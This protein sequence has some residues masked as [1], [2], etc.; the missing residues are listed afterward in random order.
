MIIIDVEN[1]FGYFEGIM[2]LQMME[3]FC[4]QVECF[5]ID[6]CYEL[7]SKVDFIGLVY[8]VWI[9]FGQEIYVNSIII[10]I[11]VSVKWL[12]L[13]FEK[14]LINKGVFVCVVCDG[15]FFCGMEIVIVGGGDMVVEEVLYFFKFSLKVYMLVCW[16]ELWVFKIMQE[17]VMNIKNIEIY[18]NIE[19]EEIFGEEEV[20][21]VCIINN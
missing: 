20:E 9:E 18:W 2:G 15:F 16:D 10:F 14:W 19:I 12:G 5:G 11:G 21:G 8:K 1:Y 6:V 7:I 3:D 4:K 17:W 13:E